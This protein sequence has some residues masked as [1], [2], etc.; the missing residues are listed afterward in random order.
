VADEKRSLRD[1][2]RAFRKR[3]VSYMPFVKRSRHE[4]ALARVKKYLEIERSAHQALGYLFFSSLPLATTARFEARAFSSHSVEELCLFVTHCASSNL[5]P[6]VVDHLDALLEC[7]VGI[8]LVANT[9]LDPAALKIPT[10]L[11]DRLYGFVIRQNT[12]YDFGAWAHAYSFIDVKRV[13]K[14]LYLINDSIV[15]PLDASA[16]RNL[17]LRIRSSRHDMVGLTSHPDPHDHLQS[18]YLVINSRLL[19]SELFD[20]FV[21]R[22]VNMPRK[23]CVI[24]VYELWLTPYIRQHGFE[25]GALFPN[26]STNP[27][28]LRNDTLWEWKRLLELGFPFIKAAVLTQSPASE[29]AM[30]LLPARYIQGELASSRIVK[31][32]VHGAT[33]RIDE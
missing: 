3:V 21:R 27:P 19:H 8:V 2:Y 5:K 22:I 15:G 30:R 13:R 32:V 7:N 6:H 10:R 18:Y 29:E 12:G 25:V 11:L 14:R 4:R 31:A 28:L 1:R 17:L 16:Y 33:T 9:D 26:L 24:D 23:E 20:S